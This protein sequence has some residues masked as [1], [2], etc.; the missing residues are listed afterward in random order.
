MANPIVNKKRFSSICIVGLNKS[1]IT[2]PGMDS[3]FADNW[4]SIT[5]EN[6]R[7][8]MVL[9]FFAAREYDG[10]PGD[11]LMAIAGKHKDDDGFMTG[12]NTV[13]RGMALFDF[14]RG[15]NADA[16][17]LHIMAAADVIFHWDINDRYVQPTSENTWVRD[18]K[19]V[20]KQYPR[21]TQVNVYTNWKNEHFDE[22]DVEKHALMDIPL[23]M[24]MWVNKPNFQEK[25][26]VHFLAAGIACAALT[27]AITQFQQS[28][29]DNL[30]QQIRQV[31]SRIQGNSDLTTLISV[32]KTQEDYMRYKAMFPIVFQ[33][34]SNAIYKASLRTS[35]L[36]LN[37]TDNQRPTNNMLVTLESEKDA[38][39]GFLEE[40]PIAKDFLKQSATL[41]AVRRP[42]RTVSTR[43]K[44][45]GLVNLQK[46]AQEITNF[47][48][49]QKAKGE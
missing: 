22:L 43:M 37:Y 11:P 36:K 8:N 27:F 46:T 13:L 16:N 23:D 12:L 14:F 2:A 49:Q 24:G 34:V 48:T 28:K 6:S 29:I 3:M 30:Q 19:E 45:E 33:D 35:S 7:K 20:I 42:K 38:Y 44:L 32:V 18:I 26:G 31:Q 9:G 1:E 5:D 40:E 15:N 4:Q 47:K 39:K 25:F 10:S 17:T 41:E 21:T